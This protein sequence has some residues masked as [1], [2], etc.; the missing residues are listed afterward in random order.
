MPDDPAPPPT[1]LSPRAREILTRIEHVTRIEH[2]AAPG[3]PLPAQAEPGPPGAAPAAHFAEA[4]ETDRLLALIN[5]LSARTEAARRQLEELTAA[6]EL[7][8]ERLARDAA[9]SPGTPAGHVATPS[10]RAYDLPA[11]P[12]AEPLPAAP[13][14]SPVPPPPPALGDSPLRRPAAPPV[15]RWPADRHHQ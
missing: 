14:A 6:L 10:R 9:P 3:E 4:D 5:A 8:T 7:L 1:E 13:L 15:V 12:A 11:P 2:A